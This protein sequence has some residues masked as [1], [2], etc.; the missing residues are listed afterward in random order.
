MTS[1]FIMEVFGPL[2][3]SVRKILDLP[4]SVPPILRAVVHLEI[5]VKLLLIMLENENLHILRECQLKLMVHV[6][7]L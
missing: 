5:G 2:N 7:L 6:V 1:N 3:D 4:D